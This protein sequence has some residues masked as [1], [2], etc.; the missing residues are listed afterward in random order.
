MRGKTRT[1][2]LACCA[3]ATLG[4]PARRL[5]TTLASLEGVPTT[6]T[7]EVGRPVSTIR[8]LTPDDVPELSRFLQASFETPSAR[9]AAPDML[10][11]KYLAAGNADARSWVVDRDGEIVAHAGVLH[12]TIRSSG[13]ELARC[14]TII[15]WAADASA[16]GAGLSL[17]RHAMGQ[18]DATYLIGG[19]PVTRRLVSRLGFRAAV[20]VNAYTRWL[21]PV[22]EF[23]KRPKSPRA[24]LRLA[25]GVIRASTRPAAPCADWR[26]QDVRRFDAGILPA[27]SESHAHPHVHRSLVA[28][29]HRLACPARAMR[30]HVLSRGGEIVGVAVSSVGAWDA[31]ILFLQAA[32][33]ALKDWTAAY[34]L[35][36]DALAEDASVCRVSV[37]TSTPLVRAAL[38]A[39]HYW[40]GPSEPVLLHDPASRFA[41]LPHVD[42]CYFDADLDYCN[43]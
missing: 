41:A 6:R 38:E 10:S 3:T 19:A 29:N 9:F 2:C 23:L 14:A 40:R 35:V 25:H 26:V 27:L 20:H 11:W 31:K 34:G 13:G 1:R 12:A 43:E 42:L 21:R 8:P 4:A 24:A 32:S 33:P 37:M 18:S 15:D 30:G 16:P 28:L 22:R 39:N 17:Y 36:T 7:L 5:G